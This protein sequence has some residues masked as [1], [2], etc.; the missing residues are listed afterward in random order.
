MDNLDSP[1]YTALE[2]KACGVSG[3]VKPLSP[4]AKVA[5]QRKGWTQ[6]IS[7]KDRP[8]TSCGHPIVKGERYA[9]HYNYSVMF[10]DACFRTLTK[11]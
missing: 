9:I 5:L 11:Q 1:Y 2:C 6:P 4:R 3:P 8:H 7:A 10:C